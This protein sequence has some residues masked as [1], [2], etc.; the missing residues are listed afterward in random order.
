[1]TKTMLRTSER[2]LFKRCQ[3]AWERS[4]VD[5]IQP[6]RRH[7]SALWFGTGIHLA[8]EKW[9]IEGKKRGIHPAET[10]TDYAMKSRGDTN[11]INTYMDG[12]FQEAVSATELGQAMMNNYVDHY[13]LEEH[14]DVI[15]TEMDFQVPLLHNEMQFNG[16]GD[17]ISRQTQSSYVGQIDLVVRDLSTGKIWL[18]D[19]KTCASLGNNQYLPLDDQAGSYWA[20]ANYILRKK[21]LIKDNEKISGIIY[22]YL[23]KRKPDERPKNA[24]G[25]ATNKPQKKHFVAQLTGEG[26]DKMKLADLQSLAEEQ[27]I[28]VLGDVS[29]QQP[30]PILDRVPVYRSSSQARSQI[31][32]IQNDLEAMSLVRNNL[33]APTKTPTKECN[34]CEFRDLCELDEQNR[35]WQEFA[36]SQFTNWD[37]YEAHRKV[38]S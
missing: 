5:Q 30:K 4:Y 14:L 9:Y 22:N 24:D 18:W 33:L 16:E 34:F 32:R 8:L 27:G 15:A 25:F 28:T 31:N 11:Y 17:I 2:N 38:Q 23:V 19:H 1:M 26:L 36:S 29:Q 12:E 35:D 7:S 21:G 10:W 3:W 37:P 13:G 6:K 20:I